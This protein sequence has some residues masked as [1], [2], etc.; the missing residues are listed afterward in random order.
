MDPEGLA[1]RIAVKANV[2]PKGLTSTSTIYEAGSVQIDSGYYHAF[3]KYTDT[4]TGRTRIARAG[5]SS[6]SSI[7]DQT[8]ITSVFYQS[9][10]LGKHTPLRESVDYL[11]E[12][13]ILIQ[14]YL[15]NT[16]FDVV[17]GTI[18]QFN[19]RVNSPNI[20]YSLLGPLNSNSFVNTLVRHS[21][22][23]NYYE[24]TNLSLP[25]SEDSLVSAIGNVLGKIADSITG[26]DRSSSPDPGS[27]D[28]P[29]SGGSSISQESIDAVNSG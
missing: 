10:T 11:P 26:N 29:S 21:T 16:D 28:D 8:P 23:D 20:I 3:F 12:K 13:S 6:I 19:T 18:R 1:T 4:E 9:T 22:G 24:H 17:S 5:P 27:R 2:V 25:G 15:I 7:L 14:N